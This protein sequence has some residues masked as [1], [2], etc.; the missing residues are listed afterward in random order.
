MS[1]VTLR[2]LRLVAVLTVEEINRRECES[3]IG[4]PRQ[5]HQPGIKATGNDSGE[6]FWLIKQFFIAFL[7]PRDLNSEVVW[8]VEPSIRPRR[9]EYDGRISVAAVLQRDS[10]SRLTHATRHGQRKIVPH[11]LGVQKREWLRSSNLDPERLPCSVTETL[12]IR[13][14]ES[15]CRIA[16]ASS[17]WWP[18]P[19][20]VVWL[21]GDFRFS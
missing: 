8:H 12:Y 7:R 14:T 19:P 21:V 6:P 18:L 4:F 10:E 15:P 3:E 9:P 16:P 2:R 11:R 17:E 20:V 5:R 1:L 13:R